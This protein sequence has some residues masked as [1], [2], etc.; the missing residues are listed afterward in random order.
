MKVAW[1]AFRTMTAAVS[2]SATLTLGISSP[3]SARYI[4]TDNFTPIPISGCDLGG[5]CQASDLGGQV[6]TIVYDASDAVYLDVQSIGDFGQLYIYKDGIVSFGRP[7]PSTAALGNPSSLGNSFAAPGFAPLPLTAV[8]VAAAFQP[9]GQT[10][11][12]GYDYVVISGVTVFWTLTNGAIV[13]LELSSPGCPNAACFDY[14]SLAGSWYSP[15]TPVAPYLPAGALIGFPGDVVTMPQTGG[16]DF[17]TGY[18]P[19][20]QHTVNLTGVPE[21]ATWIMLAA[22]GG[23]V[24]LLVRRRRR[25]G[26]GVLPLPV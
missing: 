18:S 15:D 22:G 12:F 6:G 7:L 19:A 25:R 14:G 4:A 8:E 23:G 24:G 9:T 26:C 3:A 11:A 1:L 5:S 2:L 20:F 10:D 17:L 13:G 21:P 16:I